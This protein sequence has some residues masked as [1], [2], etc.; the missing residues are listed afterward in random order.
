MQSVLCW[1]RT[2]PPPPPLHQRDVKLDEPLVLFRSRWRVSMHALKQKACSI[3]LLTGDAV[4]TS[5]KN[6]SI[7]WCCCRQ[8]CVLPLSSPPAHHG[9]ELSL[10]CRKF[11]E[12]EIAVSRIAENENLWNLGPPLQMTVCSSHYKSSFGTLISPWTRV[13]VSGEAAQTD[14][15]NKLLFSGFEDQ[16]PQH[17]MMWTWRSRKQN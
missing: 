15:S 1:R 5:Q 6:S 17:W 4:W 16:M 14:S 7:L 10:A 12:M 3:A 2:P 11:D 13:H 9:D 8:T